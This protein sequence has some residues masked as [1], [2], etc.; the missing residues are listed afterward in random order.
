MKPRRWLTVLVVGWI[1]VLIVGGVIAMRGTVSTDREQTTVAQA[2]PDVDLAAARVALAA[3]QDGQSVVAI[4]DFVRVGDCVISIFR[5]GERYKREITA[6]VTPGTEAALLQRVAA[7][8]PASYHAYV[9][10]GAAPR[11]VAD[12]GFWVYLTATVVSP[13][14]VRFVADTGSCRARGDLTTADT[15]ATASPALTA[16]LQ[17]LSLTPADVHEYAVDC[18]GG[19]RVRT[20]A[21]HGGPYPGALDAVLRDVPGATPVVAAPHLYAYTT[22]PTGVAVQGGDS[23]LITATV[24][25][26]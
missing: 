2:R 9:R 16:A 13:G 6:V 17:R 14:E 18:P 4:S 1:L 20:L 21:A 5:P 25:C 23:T 11:L 15:T 7:R 24:V 12:A 8:L 19:G 22:G 3:S 26:Q 10:T